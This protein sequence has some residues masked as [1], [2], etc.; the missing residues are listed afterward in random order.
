MQQQQV[1]HQQHQQQIQREESRDSGNLS[2]DT[3]EPRLEKVEH[4]LKDPK[5][6]VH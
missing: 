5:C 6:Q 4:N 3:D 1:Q 2:S